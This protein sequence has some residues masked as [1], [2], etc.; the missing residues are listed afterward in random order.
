MQVL[1]TI[2]LTVSVC[3]GAILGAPVDVE[4]PRT[5]LAGADKR[6]EKRGIGLA[7]TGLSGFG[8]DGSLGLA[9]YPA[10]TAYLTPTLIKSTYTVPAAASYHTAAYD[11]AHGTKYAY[12]G[13]YPAGYGGFGTA[14]YGTAFAAPATYSKIVHPATSTYTKV[15]QTYPSATVGVVSAGAAAPVVSGYGG[16]GSLGGYVY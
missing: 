2:V 16:V 3:A 13:F 4:Q 6:Q 15:I 14:G 10:T 11:A 1:A 8:Y 12:T 5:A 9:A 7:Y